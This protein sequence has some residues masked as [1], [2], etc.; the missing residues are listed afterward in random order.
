MSNIISRKN[1][2]QQNQWLDFDSVIVEH[3]IHALCGPENHKINFSMFSNSSQISKYYL[4][5]PLSIFD[6]NNFG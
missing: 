5:L 2:P 4:T 3:K 1:G 6:I